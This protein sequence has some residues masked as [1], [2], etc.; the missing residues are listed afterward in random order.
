MGRTELRSGRGDGGLEIFLQRP[1]EL[2]ISRPRVLASG[3]RYP[4]EYGGRQAG[5]HDDRRTAGSGIPPG[6]HSRSLLLIAGG[7]LEKE[8][9]PERP[10]TNFTNC[11]NFLL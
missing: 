1:C 3:I 9:S 4:R 5:E 2:G 8:L 7:T 6:P 11:T 10:A